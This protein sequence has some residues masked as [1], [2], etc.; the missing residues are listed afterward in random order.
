MPV[1]GVHPDSHRLPGQ[2]L[3]DRRVLPDVAEEVEQADR[4]GPVEVVDERPAAVV[5][6]DPVDL[7]LDGG[8]VRSQGGLVEQVALV[9]PAAGVAHH[10]GGT[11][12]EG[13]RPVPGV[14]EATQHEE[15]DE[16]PDMQAV[17]GRVDAV[18]ERD[19]SCC[20]PGRERIAVG[21]V[22]HQPTGL[23]VVEQFHR[24][25][26]IAGRVHAPEGGCMRPWGDEERSAGIARPGAAGAGVLL[27]PREL[28]AT[29]PP[30]AQ[31]SVI[32]AADGTPIVTL[33]AEENRSNVALAEIPSTSATPSSPSRTSGT[34]STTGSTSG[35]SCGPPRST[36]PRAASA[37]AARPSPSSW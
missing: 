10:A 15:P 3:V 34:G 35:R 27:H 18:V 25:D 22:L 13:H 23:E 36:P 20:Q 37:R 21:A 7:V 8:D 12:G 24:A 9:G 4:R 14:G 5:T 16:V 28:E 30:T 17:G 11:A 31:S 2:H 32:L 19:R 26:S 29:L 1:I 6:Q 33:H